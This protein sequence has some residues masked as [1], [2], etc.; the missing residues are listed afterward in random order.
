LISHS[1]ATCG[2]SDPHRSTKAS[3]T[4]CAL[5]IT[6]TK[7]LATSAADAGHW[8]PTRLSHQHCLDGNDGR[9]RFVTLHV[10]GQVGDF[11]RCIHRHA[12]FLNGC[13]QFGDAVIPYR[14]R[15]VHQD[16]TYAN[17]SASLIAGRAVK[18]LWNLFHN[19]FRPPL[20]SFLAARPLSFLRLLVVK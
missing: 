10:L 6:W 13:D 20:A 5:S 14:A 18:R 11:C 12:T 4:K 16:A 2:L 17:R 7:E 19:L 9:F 1:P 3:Y 8:H 15:A